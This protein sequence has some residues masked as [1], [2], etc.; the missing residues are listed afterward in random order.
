MNKTLPL[1]SYIGDLTSELAG[2][3]LRIEQICQ[4]LDL[5]YGYNITGDVNLLIRHIYNVNYAKSMIKKHNAKL[6]YDI[7][8]NHFNDDSRQGTIELC[9]FASNITCSSTMLA[10]K[11]KEETGKDAYI[12]ND[13]Y[14]N[15]E[16]EPTLLSGD[17][18]LWFGHPYN[19]SSLTPYINIPNLRICS[20]NEQNV[21]R[22]SLRT[23][24]D[25]LKKC[26]MVLL[27]NENIYA[28]ANRV[29]KAIRAGKFVITPSDIPSWNELKDFIWIGDPNK[30]IKWAKN[31]KEEVLDKIRKGQLYIRDK[32]APEIIAKQ[33]RKIFIKTHLGY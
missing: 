14:E 10:K 3:R 4:H 1:I 20:K 11:I 9:E 17:K 22:W 23:E 33:W 13:T 28:S 7:T 21:I 27:T 12:I 8:A 15:P 26:D 31:N 30:G 24:Q 16:I 32:F 25:E 18:L 19:L 29:V 5:T 6:I 2:F